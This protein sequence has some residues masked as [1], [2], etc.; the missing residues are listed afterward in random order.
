MFYV[1]DM[2]VITAKGSCPERTRKTCHHVFIRQG[3]HIGGCLHDEEYF[4]EEL[5]QMRQ[6]TWLYMPDG[7]KCSTL[8][9]VVTV[10]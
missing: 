2:E 5:S 3:S 9:F 7:L 8:F 10:V 1:A 4:D 6:L